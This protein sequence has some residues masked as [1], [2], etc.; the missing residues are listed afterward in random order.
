MIV[1]FFKKEYLLDIDLRTEKLLIPEPLSV[2][3]NFSLSGEWRLKRKKEIRRG[4][5]IF[6]EMKV[7]FF[8]FFLFLTS[9]SSYSSFFNLSF[10]PFFLFL[11]SDFIFLIP[12]KV[13]F[14]VIWH[15]L[16]CSVQHR[17]REGEKREGRGQHD[18]HRQGRSLV[19]CCVNLL[20]NIF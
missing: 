6:E 11:T 20:G 10:F 19:S 2:E 16:K 4:N 17:E 15:A 9:V 5:L 3:S 13:K 1:S 14:S 7:F 12:D 8:Q 18:R